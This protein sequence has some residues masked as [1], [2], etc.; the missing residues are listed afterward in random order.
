LGVP[1]K[2]GKMREL[3]KEKVESS[4]LLSPVDENSP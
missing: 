1:E 3:E 4:L 2:R